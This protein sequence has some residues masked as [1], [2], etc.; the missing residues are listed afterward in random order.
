MVRAVASSGDLA[1]DCNENGVL[2]ACDLA[3]GES[4]D[5]NGDGVPDECGN[6]C[7]GFVC[8]RW[9]GVVGSGPW[10]RLVG[11]SRTSRICPQRRLV[12]GCLRLGT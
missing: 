3:D 7:I 1:N 9:F 4:D 8:V 6:G 12:L 2:D 11:G 10:P 5:A